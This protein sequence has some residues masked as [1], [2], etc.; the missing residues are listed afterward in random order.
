MSELE[1]VCEYNGLDVVFMHV[2]DIRLVP[3]RLTAVGDPD[4]TLA[5]VIGNSDSSANEYFALEMFRLI[6]GRHVSSGD[7]GKAVV[8][9]ELQKSMGCLWE[10]GFLFYQM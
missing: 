4:S 1:G 8:S 10:T 5:Q 2:G 6:S 7:K 3:G 9:E